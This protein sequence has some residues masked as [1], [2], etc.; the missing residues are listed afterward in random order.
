MNQAQKSRRRVIIGSAVAGALFVGA[1][2]TSGIIG[3]PGS[4]QAADFGAPR[5]LQAAPTA[6]PGP[7]GPRFGRGHGPMGGN[8]TPEQRQQLQQQ[9]QQMHQQFL[10]RV[11]ANLNVT[12]TQLQ[13]AFK[14][15]RI[16]QIND[17]VKAGKLTQEQAD[18]IIA[19]IN[20]GQGFGPGGPGGPGGPHPMGKPGGTGAPSGVPG[21]PPAR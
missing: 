9:A 14:K 20:S 7:G 21:A 18:K 1:V 2:A 11:A 15:A 16:D 13:D 12:P 17:A 8:M 10:A 3:L 5:M 4:A 6:V 19:R